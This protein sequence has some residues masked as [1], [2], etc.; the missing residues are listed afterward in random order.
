MLSRRSVFSAVFAFLLVFPMLV[1]S[2]SFAQTV[3]SISGVIA[4]TTLPV[5]ITF[6][7]AAGNSVG[8]QGNTGDP[9]Y[10]NDEITTGG[11][12]NLQI[13]LKDQTVFTIGPNSEIVFDEFVYDPTNE[14]ESVLTATVSKGAFK[15]ISGKVSK[16][17][18]D[19]MKLHLPNATASIR[20]TT[21]AGLVRPDGSS[22][23]LL[24]SGAITVT[25]DAD[26]V[27]VDIFTSGW[28]TSI[29]ANGELSDPFQLSE[30]QVDG[31]VT[32]VEFSASLEEQDGDDQ[33][34]EAEETEESTDDKPAEIGIDGKP[35]S[36]EDEN[37]LSDKADTIV[38]LALGGD[39]KTEAE[40]LSALLQNENLLKIDD[41]DL[42]QLNDDSIKDVNTD[43]QL[44]ELA[45]ISGYPKWLDVR[46]V[47]GKLV[48]GND[49]ADGDYSGLISS[50]YG[51]ST[52]FSTSRLPL[53]GDGSGYAD[54]D[55]EVD[56]DTLILNGELSVYEIVLGGRAYDDSLG[57]KFEIDVTQSLGS[58]IFK[59]ANFKA[60]SPPS[61]N[62]EADGH[63]DENGN[64]LLD[65][66]E[67]FDGVQ[68]TRVDLDDKN[69]DHDAVVRVTASIGSVAN[70]GKAIDG[71]L[72]A[73]KVHIQEIDVS[74]AS[75]PKHTESTIEGTHYSKGT[76]E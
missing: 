19:A 64:G 10:L 71:Q 11:D 46:S 37:E 43:A 72:G 38:N 67:T 61:D 29:S 62:L 48:F 69:P 55:L 36:P 17:S 74:D 44:V 1:S 22:D 39:G 5:T 4:V 23:V 56:Y 41:I 50:V 9:I 45:R 3:R 21:V 18:P 73:V 58:N 35:I 34:V 14:T 16:T 33:K 30:E 49:G 42:T 25:N 57:N 68:V 66:D 32:A 54:Y 75:D 53:S 60:N 24:L 8:R 27:G 51:G 76:D 26:S 6:T 63:G 52:R 47:D 13:L 7:D 20:G 15:F 70:D 2:L 40:K 28:G 65:Q 31:I 12:S 59:R